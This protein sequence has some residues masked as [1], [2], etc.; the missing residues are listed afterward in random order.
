VQAA[1]LHAFGFEGLQFVDHPTPEPGPGQVLVRMRAFSL[2]YRDLMV[3]RGEYNPRLKMPLTVLSDGCGEVVACGAGVSRVREG[4]R[5][6]ASFMQGWIDGDIDDA[7]ARTALGAAIQG[8]AAEY[9]LFSEH[10]VVRAPEYL[11]DTEVATLPCTGVTA[12][13]ALFETGS[14]K[15]GDTVLTL[16]TG[17]VSMFAL[18]FARMGGARVIVT[19]GS[20][21]KMALA[22]E[23]GAHEVVNYATSPEWEKVVRERTGGVGVDHVI[24]VGG[25]GTLPRSLKAVRTGGTVSLIGA[26]AEGADVNPIPI[27]MRHLRVNG[28]FVGSR[29]MFEN[30]LRAIAVRQLRPVIDRVFGFDELHEALR[31]MASAKHVGKICVQVR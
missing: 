25:A 12:W 9:C 26:L 28:I 27:L 8:V 7:K 2:N 20:E 31:Y 13:N 10:G 11:S 30:M 22:R 1:E 18:Q 19:S 29:A 5:V 16:G 4:D 17:G 23:L 21:E 14:V 24:E 6:A 3:I 15:P